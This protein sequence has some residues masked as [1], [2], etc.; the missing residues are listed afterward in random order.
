MKLSARNVLK[1]K[2]KKVVT[3]AVNS[4]VIIELPGGAEMTSII[5]KASAES[6]KL[7]E[8][9]EVYAIVKASNVMIGID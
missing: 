6:L 8:G 3:G 4:E 9:S 1:G 5:T 7:K 2:V